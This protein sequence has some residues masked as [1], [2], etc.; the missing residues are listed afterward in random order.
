MAYCEVNDVQIGNIAL[1]RGLGTPEVIKQRYI[2]DTA[3]D[4]DAKLGAIFALPLEPEPGSFTAAALKRIN[5]YLAI[6]K[7]VIDAAAG[8]EDTQLHAY[9]FHHLREGNKAI[10]DILAGK[11]VLDLSPSE[12]A[13]PDD[14]PT[15]PSV[16]NKEPGSFVDAFYGHS[17]HP[18]NMPG[19]LVYP[20]IDRIF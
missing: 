17:L 7:L 11:I 2:N 8:G 5:K 10:E 12:D 19:G 15:G 1:P 6:G 13:D 20:Q 9:G 16:I 4:I 14:Q 18:S 3:D